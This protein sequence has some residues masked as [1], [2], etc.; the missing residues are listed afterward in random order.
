MAENKKIKRIKLSDTIYDLS[1]DTDETLSTESTNAVQNKVVTAKFNEV[2]DT[3]N[4]KQNKLTSNYNIMYGIT[5]I[6]TGEEYKAANAAG[7]IPEGA[8][9]VITDGDLPTT[10]G[11]SAVLGTAIL[12]TMILGQS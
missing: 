5:F 2:N 12:G 4:T 6:G 3:I 10:G 11:T 7:E 9:I 1:V 8:I